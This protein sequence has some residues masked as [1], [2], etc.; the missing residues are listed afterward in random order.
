MICGRGTTALWLALRAIRRRDGPGEVIMPDIL[1]ATALEG[2][3]LAGFLPV[4]ADVIS[5]RYTLSPESVATL[6]TPRTRAVLVVHLYGHM[7][8]IEAIRQAA[9]GIP[10]IEDAVQGLGGMIGDRPAGSFGELSFISFAPGKM[11]GGRGGVLFFDDETFVEGVK[12]DLIR[13]PDLPD[14]ELDAINTLLSPPAAAAYTHQLRA[15]TAPT[16]LRQFDPSPANLN[17]IQADWK[18]LKSRVEVRNQKAFWLENRLSN[19]PVILPELRA[20]DAIWCYTVTT[21]SVIWARRMIR[22]L[23]RAGLS[24]SGLYYPLSRLF[25]PQAVVRH[26]ENRLVNLWI[27]ESVGSD[28]LQRTV[29]VITTVPW[30]R[31]YSD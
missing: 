4:F 18:T 23:N 8:D 25:A 12:A 14:L 22:G 9:P 1:C 27:D 5:G 11:I 31:V 24:G 20:G 7:A 30:Q 3:L 29:D 15:V 13:L 6:L 10:I 16:L 17:E 2:V 26:L 21:P 28:E 19:L